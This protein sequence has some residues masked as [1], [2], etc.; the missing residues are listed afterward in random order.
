MLRRKLVDN[1]AH[2][3]VAKLHPVENEIAFARIKQKRRKRCL[4]S[5][6]RF[7]QGDPFYEAVGIVTLEDIIEDI[8]GDEIV[9]ETDAFVDVGSQVSPFQLDGLTV[10]QGL[11]R[12]APW[13]ACTC[14]TNGVFYIG[15]TYE[16]STSGYFST[17]NGYSKVFPARQW[18]RTAVGAIAV[19]VCDM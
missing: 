10:S 7:L 8:L 16:F 15:E 13:H 2:W 4:D 9:D 18:W 5:R 12:P 6:G 19:Q 11:L 1:L 17:K 14:K 3:G